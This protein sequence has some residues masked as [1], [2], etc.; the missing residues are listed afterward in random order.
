MAWSPPCDGPRIVRLCLEGL[1]LCP[2]A[3]LFRCARSSRSP[4]LLRCLRNFLWSGGPVQFVTLPGLSLWFFRTCLG[5]RGISP[6]IRVALSSFRMCSSASPLPR[7]GF[8]GDSMLCLSS[9]SFLV[10]GCGVLYF[11][12]GFCGEHSGPSLAPRFAGFTVPAQPT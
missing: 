4:E 2:L 7:L 8:L 3:F 5:F 1:Q 6:D 12:H 9:L 11:R 10:R